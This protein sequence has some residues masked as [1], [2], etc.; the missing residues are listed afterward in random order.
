MQ[1]FMTT[2][3][4]PVSFPQAMPALFVPVGTRKTEIP[5]SKRGPKAIKP[6]RLDT[7]PHPNGNKTPTVHGIPISPLN[8]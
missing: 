4:I 5:K 3:T 1:M 8:D 2:Q 6:V 7:K